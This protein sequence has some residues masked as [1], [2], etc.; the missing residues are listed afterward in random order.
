MQ[1]LARIMRLTEGWGAAWCRDYY[2]NRVIDHAFK[3]GL[4]NRLSFT[5]VHWTD[6][7]ISLLYKYT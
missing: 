4:V 1:E 3:L 2:C 7:G 6:K 5:Q